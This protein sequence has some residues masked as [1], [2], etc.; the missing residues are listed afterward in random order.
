MRSPLP[1]PFPKIAL[2]AL[3]AWGAL[4][5]LGAL[6][7]FGADTSQFDTA[8]Q[9]YEAGKFSDAK[10]AYDQLVKAGPWSAN[11][12]YNRGNAEWKLGDPGNAAADYERALAL[13][14]SHPQ[15]RANLDFVRE[16]TGA[17]TADQPWWERALSAIDANTSALLLS[18]SAWAAL[19][20]LAVALLRPAGRT[21]PVVTL[22][23]CLLLAGYAAGCLWEANGQATKA[24]VI[25]KSTQARVAPADVAPVADLLP[26]GS[27]VLAPEERGPWTYCTLPD[28]ARAWIPTD[29]LVRV[30]QT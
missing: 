26:A 6:K 27:E 10:Q 13:E 17:K 12:Y 29:A 4:T 16:Q 25:A 7:S 18:A 22:A 21:G 19:F 15:A 20:C 28:G 9:L 24:I 2:I 5:S 8:N 30:T 1:D 23:I 14:P 3:L 11:L